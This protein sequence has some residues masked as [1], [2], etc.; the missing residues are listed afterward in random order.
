VFIATSIGIG[1]RE[2]HVRAGA[3][4]DQRVDADDLAPH[5][6]QRSS[7]IARIDRDVGLD[8]GHQV[9]LW[10]VT[11]LR[12]DDAGGHRVLEP[13]RLADRDHP[14]AD[15]QL[16]RVADRDSRQVLGVDL[17]QRD[18]GPLVGADHLGRELALVRQF[19]LDF[20][21]TV[22][23]VRVGHDIAVGGDD[24]A[25]TRGLRELRLRP[26]ARQR[27]EAAEEF[28]E[29]I[30]LGQLRLVAG[31]AAHPLRHVDRH[32][33]G[34]LLFVEVG[35]VR[36]ARAALAPPPAGRRRRAR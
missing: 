11:P 9:L 28:V 35:E 18:V 12:T 34:A 30:V 21:R 2:T 14:F 26:A 16:V 10:Q 29:R 25:R 19:H 36:Q 31:A 15:L 17:D 1:E 5:V 33:G 22:D 13:E 32:D 27:P 3:R 4:V 6:E 8:E 24:E 23:D 20:V 7:G